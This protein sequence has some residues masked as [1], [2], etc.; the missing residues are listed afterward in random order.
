MKFLLAVIS[1]VIIGFG[2]IANAGDVH[3]IE[4]SL[5]D[6]F[7]IESP[8]N[9]N[10]EIEK[11]LTLRFADIKVTPK[12]GE[13]FNMM[14]YFK[15]DTSD[16]SQFD[17]PEKIRRCVE[18]SSEQYLPVIVEKKIILQKV[19]K[20]STYGFYTILTDADVAKKSEPAP[21][22][23]K[24]MTRGMVRLSRD[25]VLGFSIMSNS[26]SSKTYKELLDYVYSFVKPEIGNR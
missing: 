13:D 8:S 4:M 10:I 24:Y 22:E 20:R 2:C 21:G 6:T 23:F 11:E 7:V 19:P 12:K 1:T 17:T 25:S 26:T 16:L 15:C 9:W 5:D 18:K 14:L 3:K